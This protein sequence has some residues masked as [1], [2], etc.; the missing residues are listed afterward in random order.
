[1]WGLANGIVVLTVAG[2]FFLG[3]ASASAT[4]LLIQWLALA[5]TALGFALLLAGGA[6]VRERHRNSDWH[7]GWACSSGGSSWP[8]GRSSVW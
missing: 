3:A 5:L 8:N 7:V 2:G 4:V 1:M 6:R